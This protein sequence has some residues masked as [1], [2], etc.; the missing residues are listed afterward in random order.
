MGKKS[1]GALLL[2]FA[3]LFFLSSCSSSSNSITGSGLVWVATSGDQMITTYSINEKTGAASQVGKPIASGA[4]P[5]TMIM[6]P[7]RKTIF[8]ANVD[9]SCGANQFCNQV[10]QFSVANDGTL[11]AKGTPLQIGNTYSTPQGMQMGLALDAAG[12]VLF[13]TNQGNS[14]V[15]GQAN[16]VPGTITMVVLSSST[17]STFASTVP[18][19]VT[20]NEPSAVAVAPSGNFV[21]VANSLTNSVTA[22]SYD[23]TAG[24]LGF[25]ANYPVGTNP[26]ALAFSRCAGGSSLNSS[27]GATDAGT[28]FVA[29]SGGSNDLTIF[30][31]C[32]QVTVSCPVADGSLQ[33]VN[34]SVSTGGTGLV[35]IIPSPVLNFVY[36]VNRTSNQISQFKYSP[37][38]GQLSPLTQ[39]T[40][41]TSSSPVS[42]GVTSDGSMLV[43]ADSGTS[44]LSAYTVDSKF[45]ST[46][47]APSGRLGIPSSPTITV[48][49]QPT[50]VIVR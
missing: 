46:G 49:G 8:V 32:F 19:D 15:L 7:D 44:E 25:L 1:W 47:A 31:S 27:C 5:S 28:L 22:F 14:G 2:V 30:N 35:S 23:S 29:N 42:G 3:T 37:S 21:Y 4:Q 43:V 45:S 26:A 50:A 48:S 6:S 39:L 20:G 11:T 10:R 12:G 38:T 40:I 34:A 41:S 33:M 17:V 18:G 36:V 24:T 13:V 9:D 16:T